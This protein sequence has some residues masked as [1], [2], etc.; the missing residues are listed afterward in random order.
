M[1][2]AAA[3]RTSGHIYFNKNLVRKEEKEPNQDPIEKLSEHRKPTVVLDP[4][5]EE[6]F[7]GIQCY[8]E[9]GKRKY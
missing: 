7:E 9:I 8:R 2:E 5:E 3:R 1:T 6:N 4:W